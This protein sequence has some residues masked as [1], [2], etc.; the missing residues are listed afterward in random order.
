MLHIQKKNSISFNKGKRDQ[1][2]TAGLRA[3]HAIGQFSGRGGVVA[4]D[5]H[6]SELR[7][8]IPAD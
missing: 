7:V 3:V 4:L 5:R 6:W 2:N 1:G 8:T